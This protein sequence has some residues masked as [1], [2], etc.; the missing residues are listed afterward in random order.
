MLQL[1]EYG[2]SYYLIWDLDCKNDSVDAELSAGDF[3]LCAAYLFP[4]TNS[5][6]WPLKLVPHWQTLNVLLIPKEIRRSYNQHQSKLLMKSNSQ[7]RNIA[8]L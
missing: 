4:S 8:A 3:A 6:A 5:S 2:Y 1:Y 7:W